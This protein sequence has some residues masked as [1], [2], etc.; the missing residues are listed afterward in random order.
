MP[1]SASA[2]DLQQP[3]HRAAELVEQPGGSGI[4][5]NALGRHQ[6]CQQAGCCF[7]MVRPTEAFALAAARL[8]GEFA[9]SGSG[10][11]LDR[12]A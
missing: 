11:R 4:A 1:R 9:D 6:L 7:L 3:L 12:R 5:G 10:H 8:V 2:V